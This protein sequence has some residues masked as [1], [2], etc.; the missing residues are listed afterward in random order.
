MNSCC[1]ATSKSNLEK[2][3][4]GRIEAQERKQER[5]QEGKKTKTEGIT[6]VKQKRIC[7]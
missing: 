7:L 6:V 5:K 3:R 1:D 2:A 4:R